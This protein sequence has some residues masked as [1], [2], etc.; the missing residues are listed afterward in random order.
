MVD[1]ATGVAVPGRGGTISVGGLL[2][3]LGSPAEIRAASATSRRVVLSQSPQTSSD[4]L[5]ADPGDVDVIVAAS[6]AVSMQSH[7]QVKAAGLEIPLRVAA[8]HK[9][10]AAHAGERFLRKPFAAGRGVRS[11]SKAWTSRS[12]GR[13]VNSDLFDP[14]APG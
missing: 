11:L 3:G 8:G 4:C 2:D 9:V 7:R 13:V 14:V 1:G 6:D 5:R 12:C 10:S